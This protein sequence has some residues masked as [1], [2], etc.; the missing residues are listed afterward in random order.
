[1]LVLLGTTIIVTGQSEAKKDR[2]TV[3]AE[4]DSVLIEYRVEKLPEIKTGERAVVVVFVTSADG[5]TLDEAIIKAPERK[6]PATAFASPFGYLTFLQEVATGKEPARVGFRFLILG[7]GAGSDDDVKTFERGVNLR[8]PYKDRRSSQFDRDFE[9]EWMQQNGFNW[10]LIG[11]E[12][13]VTAAL[14]AFKGNKDGISDFKRILAPV[15]TKKVR[16]EN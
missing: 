5:P 13:K 11:A 16:A 15:S 14:V 7:L 10:K 2:L 3:N 6:K 4:K 9:W 1:M 8:L 12:A